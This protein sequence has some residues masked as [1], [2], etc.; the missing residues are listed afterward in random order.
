MAILVTGDYDHV[1]RIE[2]SG[3]RYLLKPFRFRTLSI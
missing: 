3:H 1:E 2:K